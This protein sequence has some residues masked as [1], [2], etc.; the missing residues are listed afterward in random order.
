MLYAMLCHTPVQCKHEYVHRLDRL[1]VPLL[2]RIEGRIPV[3]NA[4]S[5]PLQLWI[6]RSL[7]SADQTV[8]HLSEVT[9]EEAHLVLFVGR[10]RVRATMLYAEMVMYRTLVDRS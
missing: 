2:T 8:F 9:F 4:I 10:G 5:H 6:F 1:A 7:L 3:A